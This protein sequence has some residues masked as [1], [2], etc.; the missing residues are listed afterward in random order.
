M[1]CA[2]TRVCD[3]ALR[4]REKSVRK[5]SRRNLLL[6]MQARKYSQAP[7]ADE[8]GDIG[9]IGR[10]EPM[11]EPFSRAAFGLPLHGVSEA[12]VTVVGVHLITV[13]E[14][15]AGSVTWNQV[16]AELEQAVTRYLFGWA[17][18]RQRGKSVVRRTGAAG[19]TFFRSIGHCAGRFAAR[20]RVLL[21]AAAK[22]TWRVGRGDR[23]V[24]PLT[25]CLPKVS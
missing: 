5:L 11:P 15:R 14:E 13:L 3:D 12:V 19:R 16:R 22:A 4:V 23:R 6:R 1:R 8:G 18:D 20:K 9:F 25:E 24:K 7:S 17:A 21:T 2:A 10:H